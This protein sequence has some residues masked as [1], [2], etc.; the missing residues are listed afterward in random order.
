MK[1]TWKPRAAGISTIIS[2]CIGIGI[3]LSAAFLGEAM[4]G[5]AGLAGMVGMAGSAAMAGI[6][7][8]LGGA[9]IGIGVVA[10]IAG[11]FTLKRRRWGFALTGAILA[12][13]YGGVL[14]MVATGSILAISFLGGVLGILA[15]I[16]VSKGKK[17]FS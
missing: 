5:M 6:F 3:G 7:A 16:F 1:K 9:G 12:T 2:G 13:L 8:A 10:L 4:G 15:I 17:E 11:I 14:A